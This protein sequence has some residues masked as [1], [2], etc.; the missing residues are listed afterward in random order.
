MLLLPAIE[1]TRIHFDREKNMQ[2]LSHAVTVTIAC[3]VAIAGFFTLPK[4]H[5][6]LGREWTHYVILYWPMCLG[7]R[8]L[9]WDGCLNIARRLPWFH[10]SFTT[11]AV[12]EKKFHLK[13][14]QKMV[15]GGVFIGVCFLIY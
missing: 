6:T 11:N 7:I 15:L 13:I 4:P 10:E 3:A 5:P 1:I 14:W 8:L 2:N 12:D 9:F